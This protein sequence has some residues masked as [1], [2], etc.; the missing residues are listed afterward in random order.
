[1]IKVRWVGF[2]WARKVVGVRPDKVG[3]DL[4]RVRWVGLLWAQ[5]E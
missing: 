3:H 2:V 5:S 1:M 4:V